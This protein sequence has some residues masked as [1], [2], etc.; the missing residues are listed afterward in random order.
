MKKT[1]I[2]AAT[3]FCITTG[4]IAS[5]TIANEV[6]TT[7]NNPNEYASSGTV[8]EVSL[9]SVKVVDDYT[10]EIVEIVHP[11][12]RIEYII[13]DSVTYRLITLP[14]G[15]TITKDIKKK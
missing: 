6:N 11:G 10:G 9:N 14:T 8:S 4:A 5:N 3:A 7:T 2:L 15:R 12:A 13:G 1:L